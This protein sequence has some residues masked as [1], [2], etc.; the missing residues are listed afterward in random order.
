[1]KLKN[2]SLFPLVVEHKIPLISGVV[3]G[4]LAHG[5][6]LTN[7]FVNAD[8]LNYLFG[9]GATLDSGRWMLALTSYIFPDVSMPWIYGVITIVLLSIAACVII[10]T[11]EIRSK[12][13]QLLLVGVIVSFPAETLAFA[14]MFTAAPYALAV[15]LATLAVYLFLSRVRYRYVLCSL[16]I[17]FVLGIYQAYISLIA[18]LMVAYL[19]IKTLD[20]EWDWRRILICGVECIALLA[21]GVILYF[22]INKLIMT[23]THTEYNAYAAAS[24]KVDILKGIYVAYWTFVETIIHRYLLF[25]PTDFARFLHVG[26]IV[27]CAIAGAKRFV[28]QMDWKKKLVFVVLILVL[29]LAV[30]C[31]AVVTEYQHSLEYFS[32]IALYFLACVIIDR[33]S[34][35]RKYIRDAASVLMALLIISN[36]AFSNMVFLKQKLVYEESYG[37]CQQIAAKVKLLPEYTGEETFVFA[38]ASTNK[39]YSVPEIN[40]WNIIA[41]RNDM[42]GVYSRGDFMQDYLG[43][44]YTIENANV[45][46]VD[47]GFDPNEEFVEKYCSMTTF[48]SDGSVVKY[49]DMIIVKLS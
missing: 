43:E 15:L 41:V 5:Q 4:M 38:G 35:E 37:F 42:L 30:N 8:E 34:F 3:C 32:F 13:L 48:P 20:D 24:L 21:A 29:P 16:L 9:K 31:L 18:A 28:F 7:K 1:M 33:C 2:D 23:V 17:A 6:A 14:Y 27:L 40:M 39:I 25:V 11:F 46:T 44:A 12:I 47:Y 36:C 22:A 49:N 26:L 10:R 19:V 45:G